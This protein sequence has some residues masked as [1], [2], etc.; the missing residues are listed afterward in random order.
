MT[1]W[2]QLA[3]KMQDAE[4]LTCA[5]ADILEHEAG[6]SDRERHRNSQN[7]NIRDGSK[8]NVRK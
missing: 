5:I 1:G 4:V 2:S 3:S 8:L 6:E 7:M